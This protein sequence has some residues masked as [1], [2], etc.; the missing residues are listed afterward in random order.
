MIPRA[1]VP[2]AEAAARIALLER[3]LGRRPAPA[4]DPEPPSASPSRLDAR[5]RA[6]LRRA[7]GD[8]PLR[9]ELAR[10]RY[11]FGAGL[12]EDLRRRAPAADPLPDA[13][14]LPAD[15]AALLR[16]LAEAAAHGLAVS[17]RGRGTQRGALARPDDRPWLVLGTGHLVG[18]PRLDP[19]ARTVTV[20]GGVPLGEV[21]RA[22]R[23][24]GF[25]LD[26]DPAT[27]P[28]RSV[29]GWLAGGGWDVEGPAPPDVLVAARVA[30]PEGVLRVDDGETAWGLLA[31]S[32][33]RLGVVAEATLRVRPR[34]R[35]EAGRRQVRPHLAEA[36]AVLRAI[37]ESGAEGPDA[38]A[39]GLA[40][41]APSASPGARALRLPFR[42]RREDEAA[43][44]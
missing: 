2:A 3:R 24:R 4:P 6:H 29:G 23:G 16:L 31:G 43:P 5:V 10:R 41:C 28:D 1:A 25:T 33:G 30:T 9:D 21:E 14:V 35:G 19:E 12:G 8:E 36:L 26:A 13:V 7:L 22:V 39:V 11:A 15:E 42:R 27:P 44:T 40:E 38:P 37:G 34:P 18:T 32:A 17:V 20:A